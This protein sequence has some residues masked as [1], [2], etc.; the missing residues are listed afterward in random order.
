MLKFVNTSDFSEKVKFELIKL[1]IKWLQNDNGV[2]YSATKIKLNL[3][4]L[5]IEIIQDYFKLLANDYDSN[6]KLL[7]C[8]KNSGFSYYQIFA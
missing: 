2:T 6:K 5:I 4:L 8:L 1:K 3:Y 7:T